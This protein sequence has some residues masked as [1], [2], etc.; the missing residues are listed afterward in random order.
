MCCCQRVFI[1]ES[2]GGRLSSLLACFCKRLKRE[3]RLH[4]FTELLLLLNVG[5]MSTSGFIL[6]VRAGKMHQ[7]QDAS[8]TCRSASSSPLILD[9]SSSLLRVSVLEVPC[10]RQ[11][12]FEK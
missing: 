1:L 6:S 11:K 3:H 5:G 9:R 4:A 10:E 12:R 8:Y 7:M 2:K